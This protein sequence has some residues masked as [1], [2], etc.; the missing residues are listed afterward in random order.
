MPVPFD[1]EQRDRTILQLTALEDAL[2]PLFRQDERGKSV[3]DS[4]IH[5]YSMSDDVFNGPAS[6]LLFMP[7]ALTTDVTCRDLPVHKR[8]L[9]LS[10][11]HLEGNSR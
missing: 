6:S 2:D 4:P 9:C 10:A 11:T 1:S 8:E 7:L 3:N 5:F